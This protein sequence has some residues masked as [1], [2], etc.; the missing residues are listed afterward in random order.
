MEI[1]NDDF[2]KSIGGSLSDFKIMCELGKGSYGVI[3][4]IQ[5][6]LDN[7]IYVL[8]KMELKHMK[9]KQ[10]KESWKEVMILKKVSHQNIIKYD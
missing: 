4:K 9:E 5:S 8:K 7:N 3:Y 10:Q 1:I 6:L 2:A